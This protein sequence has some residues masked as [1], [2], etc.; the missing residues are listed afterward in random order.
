MDTL[1]TIFAALDARV[2][3]AIFLLL[4][5]GGVLAYPVL[6]GSGQKGDVKRRLKVPSP[7]VKE[8]AAAQPAKARNAT[9]EKVVKSAQD[10]YA[11]S[12][13]DNVARLRMRLIRAG[14]LDPRAVGIFFL[15]RFVA[16][17]AGGVAG[18]ILGATL[19]AE[20]SGATRWLT[21]LA[22]AAAGYNAPGFALSRQMATR[23]REYRDGFPDFM[24][25]MIVCSDA[26][27]S[28]E[29]GIERVSR[30]L[31]Q[32]YPALGQNLHL[33][34]IELRAGRSMDDALKSLAER[35]GLEEV[36]SFAT[37][38]QQSKELGTSLSG[39][40]RVFSDDMRHKRMSLAEEK[41]H[42]LPAKM[43]IPVTVCILPVVIMVAII[44]LIVKFSTGE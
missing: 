38:L 5:G 35:L 40:L 4:V 19:F 20:A 36:R 12:D 15:A 24:D 2:T 32:T 28:M 42:A 17:V 18:M 22:L 25:L 10:F 8:P 30:E 14:Y 16:M 1:T 41:A 9:Q 34:S 43:S 23:M 21:V 33:V 39:A 6:A 44:P 29:A 26:G 11:R 13:P 31:M 3:A 7:G 27:M 37:L